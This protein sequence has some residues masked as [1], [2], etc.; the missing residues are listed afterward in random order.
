M[1]VSFITDFVCNDIT[2]SDGIKLK[3]LGRPQRI[4]ILIGKHESSAP[5]FSLCATHEKFAHTVRKVVSFRFAETHYN[6]HQPFGLRPRGFQNFNVNLMEE[7]YLI[8]DFG[9]CHNK[10]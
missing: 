2:I 4:I 10:C 5:F 7:D 3:L 6:L 1:E 9:S 8:D